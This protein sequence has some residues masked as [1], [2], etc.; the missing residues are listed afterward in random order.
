MKRLLTFAMAII[1]AMQ[2]SAQQDSVSIG[3]GTATIQLG[4]VPGYYG[5]HRSVQLYTSS[6]M[7]MPQGG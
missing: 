7:N 6:E 3:A 4:P 5:N 2:L 1:F